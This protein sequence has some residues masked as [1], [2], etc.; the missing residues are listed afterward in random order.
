MVTDPWSS[1]VASFRSMS[2]CRDLL[3]VVHPLRWVVSFGQ[4]H[5]VWMRGIL[6]FV[7][8]ELMMLGGGLPWALVVL[9]PTGLMP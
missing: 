3:M 8:A 1:Q 2:W 7:R 6:A 5:P 4:G 9:L